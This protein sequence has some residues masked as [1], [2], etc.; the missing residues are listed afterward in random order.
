MEPTLKVRE[1]C[2]S[3]LAVVR[4]MVDQP[5]DATITA[6]QLTPE[7]ATIKLRV[8]KTDAGKVIGKSGRNARSLRALLEA[9]AMTTRVRITLD[10]E[11]ERPSSS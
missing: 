8:A 6:Q 3:V 2:D 11:S 10:I 5:Q 7:A 4:L 9:I 1:I